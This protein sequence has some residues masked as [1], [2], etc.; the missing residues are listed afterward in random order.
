MAGVNVVLSANTQKYVNDINKARNQGNK[1][2]D[3]IGQKAK[4]MSDEV[5]SAFSSPSAAIDG[6]LG[7]LGP[8]GLAIGAVGTA[9]VGLGIALANMGAQSAETQ[10]QLE[11]MAKQNNMSAEEMNKYGI[12]VSTTG[13]SI[14]Q[15]GDILKDTNDKIGDFLSTGGGGLQDYF[16]TIKGKLDRTAADFRGLSSLDT[17]KMIQRDLDAVGASTAQQTFVMESLASDASKLSGILR[18]NES[19]IDNMLKSYA[20]NRASLSQQTMKDIDATMKNMDMLQNNFNVAL[21]ESFSGLIKLAGAMSKSVSDTLAGIGNN[22]RASNIGNAYTKGNYKVDS[23]NAGE[24]LGTDINAIR[25][26]IIDNAVLS[27]SISMKDQLSAVIEQGDNYGNWIRSQG[28]AAAKPILEQLEA[29]IK[30]AKDMEKAGKISNEGAG[31]VGS[32]SFVSSSSLEDANKTLKTYTDQRTAIL[33]V[34]GQLETEL[35]NETGEH[36][37]KAIQA[38]IETQKTLLKAN[39][40][41]VRLASEQVVNLQKQASEKVYAE[42]RKRIAAQASLAQTESEAAEHAHALTL[43]QLESY[44]REGSLT[45]DEYNKAVEIANQK[46][47]D[48][49]I[50]I[51]KKELETKSKLE[52]DAFNKQQAIMNAQLSFAQTA[53]ERSD[54]ELAV[55]ANQVEQEAKMA[56]EQAGYEVVNEEMKLDKIAELRREHN[57]QR[58]ERELEDVQGDEQRALYKAEMQRQFLEEQHEL[59][60]I[61]EQSYNEQRLGIERSYTD[62][63][64]GLIMSQLQMTSDLFAGMKDGVEQGSSAYKALFAMEKAATIANMTLAGY[65]AWSAVDKDPTL[66][67]QAQKWVAKAMVGAQYGAQI[68]AATATTLGQFHSGTDEVSSTGSYILNAGERVI[69]PE[70]NKDLNKFL[71][72][73]KRGD[74]GNITVD[75]PFIVQGNL[76]T[77]DQDKF[78]QMLF[79]HRQWIEK[80]VNMAR[81]ERGIA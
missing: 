48:A 47:S 49:L 37:R 67:T 78:K 2:M 69:Q 9:S 71:E 16:D 44:L 53:Q 46:H 56:N 43:D 58:I 19:E 70:A 55:K 79:E 22:A 50:A 59:G 52:Q 40:E 1:S 81:S 45:N 10:K 24:L 42:S 39:D 75:A 76:D 65:D 20:V 35:Q 41:N 74:S 68:A 54:L 18:M 21:A 8:A 30:L 36:T 60:L 13:I 14:E 5:T 51:K 33:K 57:D 26:Q 29:D 17:L 12:A 63:R 34:Q 32:G 6:F 64:R 15:F 77:N 31:T 80:S 66:I 61:S 4:D 25:K 27:N 7:R 62:A 23:K 73:Q 28:E 11:L 3:A 72:S 38:Q